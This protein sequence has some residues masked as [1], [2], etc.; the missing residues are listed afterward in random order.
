[1]TVQ[2]TGS[3][4]IEFPGTATVDVFSRTAT[5]L[6]NLRDVECL[7]VKGLED[8]FLLGRRAMQEIDSKIDRLSNNLWARPL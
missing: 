7:V 1:M 6:L 4:Q 3:G 2:A 5:R 8:Q